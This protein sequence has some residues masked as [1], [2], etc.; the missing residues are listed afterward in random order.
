MILCT[1]ITMYKIPIG[2]TDHLSFI[3]LLLNDFCVFMLLLKSDSLPICSKRSSI[4]FFLSIQIAMKIYMVEAFYYQ[5]KILRRKRKMDFSP[6]F[7]SLSD[8]IGI[9]LKPAFHIRGRFEKF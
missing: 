9:S 3:K 4:N 2:C 1:I 6:D 8:R 7:T 5:S